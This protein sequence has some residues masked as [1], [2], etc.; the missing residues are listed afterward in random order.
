MH[1]P[2][3]EGEIVWHVPTGE[4]YTVDKISRLFGD[5]SYHLRLPGVE[6]ADDWYGLTCLGS[7][8]CTEE[9][10]TRICLTR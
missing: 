7:E 9:E 4:R 2:F 1:F 8:L 5:A 3:K 10:W 6:Y